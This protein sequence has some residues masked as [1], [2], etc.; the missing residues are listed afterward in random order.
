MKAAKF[1]SLF[2][3]SLLAF[4]SIGQLR[5]VPNTIVTGEA[6]FGGSATASGPSGMGTTTITFGS[7]WN[8]IT[9]TGTYAGIMSQAATFTPSFS[10]TGDGNSVVL[11]SA[12]ITNFWTFTVM[13]GNTYSF[14]LASLTNGHV[15]A[16]AISFTGTGTLFATGLDATPAT[17]S[18]N[19]TGPGDLTFQLS[20]VTN[21][22]TGTP[23]TGSTL[24]LMSFGLIG[25][26]A[27][28]RRIEGQML[29]VS[30]GGNVEN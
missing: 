22:A 3:C 18:L 4:L 13:G 10:F 27:C 12:P 30:K 19:G 8:F 7:N 20:F 24:L 11:L 25:L 9:G 26:V 16:T 14:D 21:T 28:G 6:T 2:G 23:D 5:A 17:F 29:V 1:A 15:E